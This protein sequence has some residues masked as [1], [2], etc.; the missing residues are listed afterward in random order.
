MNNSPYSFTSSII[1]ITFHR[2]PLGALQVNTG[3]DLAQNAKHQGPLIK[4]KSFGYEGKREAILSN[5][6]YI[7]HFF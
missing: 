1:G 3:K 4:R 7:H 6:F 2:N 5:R